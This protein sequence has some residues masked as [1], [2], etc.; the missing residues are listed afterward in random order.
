MLFVKC[1]LNVSEVK[2]SL[3]IEI[4]LSIRKLNEVFKDEVRAYP[5]KYKHLI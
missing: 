4:Y 2:T 5:K 3:N 1:L